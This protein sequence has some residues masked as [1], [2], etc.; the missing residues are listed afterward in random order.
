MKRLIIMVMLLCMVFQSCRKYDTFEGPDL[1]DLLGEFTI[2]DPVIP[3]SKN[4]NFSQGEKLSFK[5]ELSKNTLWEIEFTGSESGARGLISGNERLFTNVNSEWDGGATSFP[6]FVEEKVYLSIRFP[7]EEDSEVILDTLQI[8]GVK[9]ETGFLLADFESGVGSNW[10]FFN[11][12][13]V[14]G[15]INCEEL[16]A[17]GNCSYAIQG[18]VPWDWAI[19]SVTIFP[20]T[21]SFGLPASATDLFFNIGFKVTENYGPENSFLLCWFDEDENGDGQFDENSED[22]WIYEHW[23]QDTTWELISKRYSDL[24]TIDNEEVATNGNGLLEPSKIHSINLFFLANPE[25]GKA[26][27]NIDHLIFTNEKPYSP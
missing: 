15:G 18:T 11:Q 24:K 21:E 9:P 27:A 20:A 26:K 8:T 6:G 25:N 23:S 2:L 14:T 16:A 5:G 7:N 10:T 3:S 19:G 13:T 22:R 12:S 4:I 17:K 1:N